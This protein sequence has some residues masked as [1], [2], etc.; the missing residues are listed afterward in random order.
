M[1]QSNVAAPPLW[2]AHQRLVMMVASVALLILSMLGPAMTDS[3]FQSGPPALSGSISSVDKALARVVR[4][5]VTRTSKAPTKAPA[6][7]RAPSRHTPPALP[8]P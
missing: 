5:L 1:P 3:S 6:L 4:Q 2:V 7:G 8:L